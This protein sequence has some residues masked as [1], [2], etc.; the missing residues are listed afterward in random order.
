MSKIYG[1][2]LNDVDVVDRAAGAVKFFRDYSWRY[3]YTMDR[4]YISRWYEI[5]CVH[6]ESNETV[7]NAIGDGYARKVLTGERCDQITNLIETSEIWDFVRG[8][9]AK[10]LELTE[11]VTADE[12]EV[13]AARVAAKEAKA[14]AKQ[15][16][17]NARREERRMRDQQNA[18]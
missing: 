4:S 16:E 18:R 11:K 15:A 6:I 10:L 17:A 2:P 7:E 14:A 9:E 1:S 12:A 13:A 3:Q 8:Y 5:L